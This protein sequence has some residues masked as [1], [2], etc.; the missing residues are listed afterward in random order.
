[1]AKAKE[2]DLYGCEEC[3]MVVCV[4]D[5]CGCSACEIICCDVPMKKKAG[6]ANTSRKKKVVSKAKAAPRKAKAVRK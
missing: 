1:M 4:E 3:G 6:T 5:P 2:G